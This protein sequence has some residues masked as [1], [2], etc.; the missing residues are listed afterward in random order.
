L[1]R[2]GGQPTGVDAYLTSDYEKRDWSLSEEVAHTEA[3]MP[4]WAGKVSWLGLAAFRKIWVVGVGGFV[5]Q[6]AAEFA[7]VA[8]AG[9]GQARRT[10]LVEVGAMVRGI[11]DDVDFSRNRLP[12]DGRMPSCPTMA[13][14]GRNLKG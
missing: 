13:L 11:T 7:V 6:E 3:K 14:W 4:R 10:S 5:A 12:T 2:P 8:D 9:S 1:A